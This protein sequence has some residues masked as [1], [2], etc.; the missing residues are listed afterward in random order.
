MITAYKINQLLHQYRSLTDSSAYTW[1]K[2]KK[3]SWLLKGLST[4]FASL[5]DEL[6]A[7][8]EKNCDTQY[9]K[10]DFM[11]NLLKVAESEKLWDY[12]IYYKIDKLESYLKRFEF[13]QC[14]REEAEVFN[15]VQRTVAIYIKKVNKDVR[16]DL[17]WYQHKT[18]KNA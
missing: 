5:L 13:V 6:T 9:V 4:E 7:Y 3:Y 10:K 17:K 11:E 8:S 15:K 2:N 18:F 16:M 1:C 12:S 14:F